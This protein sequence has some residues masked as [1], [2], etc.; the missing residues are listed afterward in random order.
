MVLL[1]AV[2][3]VALIAVNAL[4][5]AA[6]FAAVS[7]RQSRIHALADEGSA[8][9]RR[10][11][12]RIGEPSGQ[13]RYVACCQ[14]GIT[15][16]SLLLG[17]VGQATLTLPLSSALREWTAIQPGA[18]LS[19]SAVAVLLFL[20]ASQMVL[21][22]LVPK[23]L[24]LQYPTQVA[25]ATVMP[26]TWSLKL[27]NPFIV[28]LN[29]SGSLLLRIFGVRGE[30][31][32]HIHSPDEIE[33]L[34]VDSRDGG[35]LEPEEQ[36]RLHQ[37]LR[38]S[39]RP[40]HQLMVPRPK[41]VTIDATTPPDA[42]LRRVAESPFSRLP[43]VRGAKDD[44]V[45]VL[46]TKDVIARYIEHGRLPPIPQLMRPLLTV[47][48]NVTADR[49]LTL[50][51]EHRCQQAALIDEYGGVEG[52]VTLEDI[53]A[54]VFGDFGDEFKQPDPEPTVLDDGRI[55]ATGLTR[56]DELGP[57]LGKR[58]EGGDAATVG[59]LALYSAGRLPRPGEKIVVDGVEIEIESLSDRSVASVLLRKLPPAE[60][61]TEDREAGTS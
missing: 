14:V 28:V 49:L 25:L 38:L 23:S 9:A 59:G 22:E 60:I 50:F 31:H 57:L 44:V 12:K 27:F 58:L 40:V 61:E 39:R 37:A 35:L 19:T 4:Y 21:G 17:A 33:L 43:V 55:R 24:A 47:P 48:R 26:M 10:L 2:L 3:I 20:T 56:L 30:G 53:L 8:L 34:I 51:R 32:R 11:L 7:V 18:A 52:L 36:R 13:D 15:L 6:E 5:V 16:S 54:E 1:A 45:G 42:T 29:G 46:Y 41:M